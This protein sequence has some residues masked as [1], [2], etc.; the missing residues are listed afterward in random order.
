M[1]WTE[2]LAFTRGPLFQVALVIFV[3]GMLYRLVRVLMLGWQK[4]KV[5]AKGS[6]AVGVVKSFLKGLLIFPFIPWVKRTFTKNPVIYLAGGLFH[7]SLFVVLILGAAHMLVWKSLLGFGWWT[8]PLPIVDW[9]AAVG[10]VAMV[11][12]FINR[13]FNPVLKLLTGPAEWL[14]LAFVFLPMVS[15]Y[16]LTHHLFFRY[17]VMF[18]IHM[19]TVDFLLIWIPLSRI[20]HFMFYFFSRAIHG[21]EFGKRAVNP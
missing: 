1:N 13:L 4:D 14:N 11:A 19:L 21:Q 18:S 2:I 5:P 9:M 8:L 12:L 6:K 3:A 7:L 15:G 10:I 17:E 20:S 16:M